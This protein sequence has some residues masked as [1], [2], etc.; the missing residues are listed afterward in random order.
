MTGIDH[1]SI[2]GDELY[3]SATAGIHS[4]GTREASPKRRL[5][6]FSARKRSSRLVRN[7]PQHPQCRHSLRWNHRRLWSRRSRKGIV[8]GQRQ[9][10]P[11]SPRT[12]GAPLSFAT[13]ASVA[14]RQARP[15]RQRKPHCAKYPARHNTIGYQC[16]TPVR[17]R[18]AFRYARQACAAD[19]RDL[20]P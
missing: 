14:D 13:S 19:E 20:P 18:F 8:S 10:A 1:S 9:K 2:L 5:M 16:G 17:N 11:P 3:S 4:R 15:D 12:V 7:R 6:R